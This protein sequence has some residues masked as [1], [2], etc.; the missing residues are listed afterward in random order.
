MRM[1][2]VQLRG[3][4]RDGKRMVVPAFSAELK[5]R[6]REGDGEVCYRRRQARLGDAPE[7]WDLAWA[8][9]SAEPDPRG[10]AHCPCETDGQAQASQPRPLGDPIRP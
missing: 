8:T 4:P 7:I 6:S 5:L 9:D 3:G 1:K 10:L 2:T